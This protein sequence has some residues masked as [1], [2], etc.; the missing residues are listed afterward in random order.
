MRPAAV[1]YADSNETQVV[2]LN[3]G[4]N[5]N[6]AIQLIQIKIDRILEI[7]Y[8]NQ[9]QVIQDKNMTAA[10]VQARTDENWRILGS[11]FGRLQSELLEKLM[12]RVFQIVSKST[13][14][15]GSPILP[16]APEELSGATLRLKYVSQLAKAQKQAD[17]MGIIN[18]VSYAG[19]AAQLNPAI[20]DNIDFDT[21]IRELGDLYGAP[22][23]IFMDKQQ[24]MAMRQARAQ[25]QAQMMQAQQ[26]NAQL[27]NVKTEA[28]AA[29]KIVSA[30]SK[31][32]E[33]A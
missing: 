2:P 19:E 26:D 10:E 18:T 7:Y 13:R 22:S 27:Q 24:M 6:I 17:I 5:P 23:A 8:N 15:D 28:E 9:L 1:N 21:A 14:M 29:E 11:V 4:E 12:N 3:L 31:L 30:K 20:L 33:A 25:Q 32:E 16:Q